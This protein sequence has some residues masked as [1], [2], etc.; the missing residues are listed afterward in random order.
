[1]TTDNR[2]NF[3]ISNPAAELAMAVWDQLRMTSIQ[4]GN[5]SIATSEKVENAWH[6]IAQANPAYAE[7]TMA[8]HAAEVRSRQERYALRQL[9][10]EAYG[11]FLSQTG[12]FAGGPVNAAALRDVAIA[13]LPSGVS[14]TYQNV[15]MEYNVLVNELGGST[16]LRE[17]EQREGA[18]VIELLI[19][20]DVRLGNTPP[21]S[22]EA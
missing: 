22:P 14:V 13:R 21:V 9:D 12:A 3:S 4:L 11:T 6:A 20:S 15:F 8:L 7:R 18:S 16:A 17:A 5:I 1:M 19:T 2:A 10:N